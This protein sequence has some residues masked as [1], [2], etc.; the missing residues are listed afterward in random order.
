MP[1]W[2][3]TKE[4]TR[5]GRGAEVGQL[6]VTTIDL[7]G[8]TGHLARAKAGRMRM[9]GMFGPEKG[10][11]GRPWDFSLGKWHSAYYSKKMA[12]KQCNCSVTSP[13]SHNPRLSRWLR[14]A[15]QTFT[16]CC[17]NLAHLCPNSKAASGHLL[18]LERSALDRLKFYFLVIF[19][20]WSQF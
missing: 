7:E 19:N 8:D 12:H 18:F 2:S 6:Y 9:G 14:P 4:V 10:Q 13:E 3:H 1:V 20:L 16:I 5:V 17:I 11:E 15:P